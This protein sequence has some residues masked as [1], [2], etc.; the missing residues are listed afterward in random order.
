MKLISILP[1]VPS[2]H[3]LAS[4]FAVPSFPPRQ[5]TV[6]NDVIA[7]ETPAGSA[8][9]TVSKDVQ[10]PALVIATM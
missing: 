5:L 4:A 10:P 1:Q 9:L 3:E 6:S 7:T 2:R 8:I